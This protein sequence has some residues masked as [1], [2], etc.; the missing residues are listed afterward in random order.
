MYLIHLEHFQDQKSSEILGSY[1]T[2]FWTPRYSKQRLLK[3]YE[4]ELISY[5]FEIVLKYDFSQ[6]FTLIFQI[7]QKF[8]N[9]SEIKKK[10]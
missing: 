7:Q 5:L 6:N 8:G 3:N 1:K 2:K 9:Y 4:F 10:S